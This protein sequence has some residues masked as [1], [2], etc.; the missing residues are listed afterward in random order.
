VQ[1]P[2]ARASSANM[3]IPAG[4]SITY[5][6]SRIFQNEIACPSGSN[7]SQ[8]V[9]INREAISSNVHR[10]HHQVL[11]RLGAVALV[12][13]LETTKFAGDTRGQTAVET[14]IVVADV[15]VLE[16]SCRSLLTEIDEPMNILVLYF[17]MTR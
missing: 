12:K 17:S 8:K 2:T 4:R 14:A 13:A 16:S 10:W 9:S 6:P 11:P 7:V 1:S 5:S 15:Q 3:H